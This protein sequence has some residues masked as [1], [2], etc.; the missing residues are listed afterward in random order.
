MTLVIEQTA[1]E[2]GLD[3]CQIHLR[4]ATK[5]T[6]RSQVVRPYRAR[7]RFLLIPAPSSD[8]RS[9][10]IGTT[11]TCVNMS[12]RSSGVKLVSSMPVRACRQH[13]STETHS[14]CQHSEVGRSSFP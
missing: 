3:D 2:V 13:R 10:S 8:P 1:I 6:L 5:I 14:G 9:E 12:G 11:F 4:V 7:R